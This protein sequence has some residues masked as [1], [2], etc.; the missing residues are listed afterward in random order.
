MPPLVHALV[1]VA[2][3]VAKVIGTWLA[4]PVDGAQVGDH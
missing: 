4:N 1:V 3:S 2:S